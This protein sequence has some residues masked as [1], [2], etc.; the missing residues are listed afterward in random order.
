[1]CPAVL[2]ANNTHNRQQLHREYAVGVHRA[3]RGI[4]CFAGDIVELINPDQGN[5]VVDREAFLADRPAAEGS[6]VSPRF[7]RKCESNEE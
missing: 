1:M 7:N 6:R 3:F 5:R 2:V 4:R